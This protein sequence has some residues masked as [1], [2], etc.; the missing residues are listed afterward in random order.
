MH[1]KVKL[2]F[3]ALFLF[4]IMALALWNTAGAAGPCGCGCGRKDG[5]ICPKTCKCTTSCACTQYTC[6][7][8][9][10]NCTIKYC[11]QD[12]CKAQNAGSCAWCS[13]GGT[14]QCGG[15][16]IKTCSKDNCGGSCTGDGHCEWCTKG[17]PSCG[18]KTKNCS[19]ACG[20]TGYTNPKHNCTGSAT[21]K[22]RPRCKTA[23]WVDCRPTNNCCGGCS[24]RNPNPPYN[25]GPVGCGCSQDSNPSRPPT[26][27]CDSDPH[28]NGCCDCYCGVTPNQCS[29]T[30]GSN[31]TKPCHSNTDKCDWCAKHPTGCNDGS[32][33]YCCNVHI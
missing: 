13:V 4:G 22:C 28:C 6:Q 10:P 21:G 17:T 29:C 19:E 9:P 25:A 32:S 23:T 2:F 8:S 31:G 15:G 26:P 30:K 5:C 18:G 20:L 16:G 3:L 14:A 27:Q 33:S 7:Q 12:C 11:S 1:N 24:G